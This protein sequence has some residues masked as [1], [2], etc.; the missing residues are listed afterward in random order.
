MKT[1]LFETE[2]HLSGGSYDI[3]Y[4]KPKKIHA[5]DLGK[6]LDEFRARLLKEDHCDIGPD[7]W[8][9]RESL[10]DD[11]AK[12]EE[13]TGWSVY[14]IHDTF[15]DKGNDVWEEFFLVIRV[16]NYAV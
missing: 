6:A 9:A 5:E 7:A 13:Q 15:D 1:Y 12:P 16:F 3:G 2:T 11:P 14:A 8:D 10:Y 4:I